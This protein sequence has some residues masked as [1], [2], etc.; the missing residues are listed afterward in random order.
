MAMALNLEPGTLNLEPST[1]N[2]KYKRTM[3]ELPHFTQLAVM[4]DGAG[5]VKK[6]IL[7]Q[8]LPTKNNSRESGLFVMTIHS[9]L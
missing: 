2:G 6:G 4:A 1:L 8:L 9:P 5:C 3:S 7:A